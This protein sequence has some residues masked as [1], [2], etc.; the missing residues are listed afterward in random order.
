MTPVAAGML[1]LLLW[2]AA[3][4]AW[5]Q[6]HHQH[7][8][9][10]AGDASAAGSVDMGEAARRPE[11]AEEQALKSRFNVD[12]MLR[13]G[14]RRQLFRQY[15]ETLGPQG[16]LD[17]LERRNPFCHDE[18][19]D[20]GRAVYEHVKDVGRA[21]QA[22]GTRCTR[23]CAHGV[24]KQAFGTIPI[25]ELRP[26]LAGTCTDGPAREVKEPGNCAHGMGHALMFVLKNDVAKSI[27]A[28]QAFNHPA[29]AYYCAT[30]VYMELFD[31]SEGSV[32]GASL[33]APC[34]RHPEFPA[35]CYRYQAVRMLRK[36]GGDREKLAEACRALPVVEQAGCFHGFGFA[37]YRSVAKTP[38]LMSGL[39]PEAPGPNQTLCIEGVAE[40]LAAYDRA[41]ALAACGHLQ[42]AAAEVCHAAASQALYRLTKPSFPLYQSAR[43]RAD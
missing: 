37:H 35:A 43:P 24:L 4:T 36:L 17:V 11:T 25:D 19:H 16:M 3:A 14:Q 7:H 26:R 41:K 9:P 13:A 10:P 22:C 18:A 32:T 23:A 1:G 28:C 20:L 40:T 38:A 8:A 39:C 21:L 27:E 30:G 29:M 2:V 34:D 12:Y 31:Q 6:H 42:G 5:A 15:M 33:Y